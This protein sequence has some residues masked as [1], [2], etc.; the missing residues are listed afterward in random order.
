M[1]K[2]AVLKIIIFSVFALVVIVLWIVLYPKKVWQNYVVFENKTF[3][4]ELAQTDEE[5][6]IWLMYREN[7]DEN[8]WMLFIF[9]DEWK[10]IFWMKNTLIPLDMVRI[11]EIN[12]ENRVVD[13]Q[14]AKPCITAECE[15]YTPSWDSKFVLEIN[16]WLAEKYWINAWDLVYIE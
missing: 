15:I 7:L 1:T 8:K 5:R 12:W 6:Q 3:Q 13:I 2:K 4:I 11:A 14:T 9:D 10:H 16:A